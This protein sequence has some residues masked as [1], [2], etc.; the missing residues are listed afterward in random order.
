MG[1]VCSELLVSKLMNFIN[2]SLYHIKDNKNKNT[3]I[4]PWITNGIITFIEIGNNLRLPEIIN[5]NN[6]EMHKTID[7]FYRNLLNKIINKSKNKHYVHE[8]KKTG[9]NI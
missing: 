4:K 1:N 3:K 8:F 5:L 6:A 9:N 2:K 7:L